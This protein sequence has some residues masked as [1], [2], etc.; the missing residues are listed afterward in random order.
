MNQILSDL[1][2]FFSQDNTNDDI[3]YNTLKN[4]FF[5]FVPLTDIE[6]SLTKNGEK[7]LQKMVKKLSLE[8]NEIHKK[9]LKE[10]AS[11]YSEKIGLEIDR[12]QYNVI[13]QNLGVKL[14]IKE[15]SNFQ[16]EGKNDLETILKDKSIK[17]S[18]INFARKIYEKSG[19][20][21][22]SLFKE[23]IEE[24]VENEKEIN[25]LI[26]NLNTNI[27]EEITSKIDELI[28]EIKKYQEIWILNVIKDNSYFWMDNNLIYF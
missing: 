3:I 12:V 17:Y 24:I 23:S 28:N 1:N 15:Y 2:N 13:N 5:E 19:F 16:R 25:D 7:I 27:S 26:A 21:F 20:K 10:F 9:K 14:N 4:V 22:K 11:E 8:I 18:N 6:Q